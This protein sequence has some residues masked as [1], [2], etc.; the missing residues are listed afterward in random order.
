MKIA[1]N[2]KDYG[3]ME[4]DEEDIIKFPFGIYA[5]EECKE[6]VIISKNDKMQKYLQYVKDTDPRFI[7]FRPQDLF[8]DYNPEIPDWVKEEL[9]AQGDE[10][11]LFLI[12]NIPS[13]IK[14]MT[15]N[16][17]SPIIIN[18]KKRLGTQAILEDQNFSVRQR[19]F[20]DDERGA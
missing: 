11:S 17:K 9:Q 7:I 2:T 14:N 3:E 8:N 18:F 20:A 5:F 4:F 1:V 13:K 12:A 16:L 6:F 15:V 10:L 19:V